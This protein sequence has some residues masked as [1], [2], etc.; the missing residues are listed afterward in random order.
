MRN[1]T[2]AEPRSISDITSKYRLS[3]RSSRSWYSASSFTLYTTI[4]I[5]FKIEI[6]Y[7]IKKK[8][9][10]TKSQPQRAL[11]Y[12]KKTHPKEKLESAF[13]SCFDTMWNG[14]LDISKPENLATALEKTFPSNSEVAAIISAASSPPIKAE[15]ATTTERVIKEQG[16]FGCPWFWVMNGEGRAEPFF[17]SDR[18]HYM[19]EYLG[20]PFEDLKL[21]A[22]I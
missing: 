5:S 16:A 7:I 18:F 22:R 11:T 21:K 3:F 14:H 2:A 20:L 6:H 9:Q 4:S 1:S 19:W 10:L 17:G 8:I 13:Q 15:L 12:I